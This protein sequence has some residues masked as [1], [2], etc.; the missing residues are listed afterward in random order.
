MSAPPGIDVPGI[1][2]WFAENVPAAQ[3]PLS[4]EL[5]AGGRSNLTFTVTDAQGE[6]WVLRR[7]P[8]HSVLA[9]AHDV[10]REKR[11]MEALA[12]TAVPV[13]PVAGASAD[14]SVTGAPFFVMEFVDGLILRDNDA[15]ESAFDETGR[16]PVADAMIDTLAALH[17]V[18]P[19][20]VGLG[21]LGRREGYIARQLRRWHGQLEQSQERELPELEEAH[22]RLAASIPDQGPA[23]IVH[24][25]YR[26]DNMIVTP[27]AQVA[28]VLDWELCTL[29]DPLADM[30]LLLVYWS[31]P[32]R[33]APS[34][35]AGFPTADELARR[36]GKA[37]GRDLS[38]L[39][40][41]V[42]FGAWK[43]AV[44]IEGVYARYAAGA[45]GSMDSEIAQLP[46]AVDQLA[47]AALART[48]AL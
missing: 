19:D 3:P 28:A 35:L 43:L 41:Y 27:A 1:T 31:G 7:P 11:V 16:R 44:I 26:L 5:I 22:R 39:D 37:S 15:I 20:A 17:T 45:Y 18:E 36:Y 13:P 34:S 38:R 23:A 32:Y 21:E 47:A 12:G 10:L 8:L 9:S 24:G 30:G 14:E 4:F 48:E 29:G 2:S 33:S 42:A 25:D 40:Y 46:E 6:R